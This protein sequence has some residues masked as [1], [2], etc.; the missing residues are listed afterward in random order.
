M[1][2]PKPKHLTWRKHSPYQVPRGSGGGSKR[3]SMML[4]PTE[5]PSTARNRCKTCGWAEV[6]QREE[7]G[8]KLKNLIVAIYDRED[9]K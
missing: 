6:L 9:T 2:P 4:T 5:A 8:V 3:G 7:N 1:T